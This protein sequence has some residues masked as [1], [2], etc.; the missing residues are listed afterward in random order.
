MKHL[1]AVLNRYRKELRASMGDRNK[2]ARLH[3]E[4]T[5]KINDSYGE[6][7]EALSR[8][9]QDLRNAMNSGFWNSG[10]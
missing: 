4:V 3:A 9:R 8:F 5:E 7:K 2:L 6:E 10:G 1:E